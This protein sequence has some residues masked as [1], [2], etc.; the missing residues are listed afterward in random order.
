[1]RLLLFAIV[2]LAVACAQKPVDQSIQIVSLEFALTDE[3]GKQPPDGHVFATV[4]ARHEAVSESD[5]PYSSLLHS[6]VIDAANRSY[7]PRSTGETR[8]SRT[9]SGLFGMRGKIVK[10]H[11]IRLTFEVPS[12]VRLREVRIPQTH[13]LPRSQNTV[14]RGGE[15]QTPGPEP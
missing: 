2:T 6:T 3:Q 10:P 9:S 14:A 15:P 5:C 7:R 8:G 11:E 12:G 4:R 13:L 1:M